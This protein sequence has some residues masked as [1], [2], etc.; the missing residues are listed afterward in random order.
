M[1]NFDVVVIGLGVMGAAAAYHCA[2]RGARVLGLD[3]NGPHHQL[4]SSH[5]ATRATRETYFESP[6]YVSLAQRSFELWRELEAEAGVSLLQTNGGLY[7][8]PKGHPLLIG[9][10]RAAELHSLAIDTLSRDAMADRFPGFS[11]PEGWEAVFE[12]RGG[13]LQAESC[14]NAFYELSRR[15]GA[16]LN[17]VRAARSWRQTPDGVVV[18]L[19]GDQVRAK[20]VILTLG[21]WACE[22]LRELDLPISGR[23]I[24]VIHFDTAR[25]E[26]YPE[27][28]VSIYFWATPHGIFAGFPHFDGEGVKIVRH[29]RG[30]VCTPHTIRREV[31]DE[32]VRE[33]ADFAHTYM[34]QVN[35][36]LR[37]S[38]VCLYTMTPDNHFV[39]DRHPGF[40]SLVYA[41]GFSG[42]GFK[43]AP[44]VGEALADLSLRG[45]TG[46][47]IGFLSAGRFS[48]NNARAG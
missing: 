18:G 25:P 42:H 5:G 21:P 15:Y 9:V 46:L 45:S 26:M 14:L 19:D 16:E 7:I 24:P 47:P 44:V 1:R 38:L 43:F 23:R 34:P 22:S 30:D 6:D 10:H 48:K 8:A 3:A 39:I 27:A 36:G 31:T 35:G 2:K 13:V 32:D 11:V 17:F 12:R 33:V 20:S 41:T 40:E 4:G 28:N 37:K 29:D